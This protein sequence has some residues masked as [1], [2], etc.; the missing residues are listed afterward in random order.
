VDENIFESYNHDLTQFSEFDRYSI[1]LYAIP[2]NFNT[3]GFSV[4]WNEGLS[5]MDKQF[6][7]QAYPKHP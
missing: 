6:I 2:S 7:A 5:A 1:M 4:G 3:N